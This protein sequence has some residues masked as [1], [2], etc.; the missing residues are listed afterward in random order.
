MA[1]GVESSQ[2]EPFRERYVARTPAG[3]MAT[4]VDIGGTLIYLASSASDYVVGQ[5]IHVDGGFT[6]W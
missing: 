3:R 4:P 5:N 2:P 1:G 6:A